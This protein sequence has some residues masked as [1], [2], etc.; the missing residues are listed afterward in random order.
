MT[1]LFVKIPRERIGVLI[2]TNG[3]VKDYIQEKLPVKLDIDS[4][5]GDVTITLKK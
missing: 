3:S 4:E 1:Q 2:G 5:T